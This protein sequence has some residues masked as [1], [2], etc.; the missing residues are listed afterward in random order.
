MEAFMQ[1]VLRRV[2]TDDFKAQAVSLSETLG[3]TGAARKLGISVKSL[4]NWVAAARKT[5]VSRASPRRAV[6]EMEAELS[7]L[8]AENELLKMERDILKKATAFFAK[9]SR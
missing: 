7:R 3:R 5:P 9:E 4:E 6:S 1:K 8:R 2:F